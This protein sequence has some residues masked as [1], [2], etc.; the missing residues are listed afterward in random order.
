MGGVVPIRE[1]PLRDRLAA[2]ASRRAD[3]EQ[4]LRQ[5]RRDTGAALLEVN[6]DDDLTLTAAAV[7]LDLSRPTVY[8]LLEDTE[9]SS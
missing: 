1:Q 6:D 7:I 5:V 4:Q 3:L 8:C 9:A 2:L